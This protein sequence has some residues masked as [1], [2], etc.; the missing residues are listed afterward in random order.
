MFCAQHSHL[1]RNTRIRFERDQFGLLCSFDSINSKLFFR[2]IDSAL[3]LCARQRALSET[4]SQSVNAQTSNHWALIVAKP[5]PQYGLPIQNP[6]SADRVAQ[7]IVCRLQ[8][9]TKLPKQVIAKVNAIPSS[10]AVTRSFTYSTASAGWNG[11]LKF[12]GI[13]TV[14][15]AARRCNWPVSRFMIG[16][17]VSIVL[18][19]PSCPYLTRSS[20]PTLVSLHPYP[21]CGDLRLRPA[22]RNYETPFCNY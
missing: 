22:F 2:R 3:R 16:L 5:W 6:T 19:P 14:A 4:N 11:C 21:V 15:S 7:Q 20:V 9:P 13:P 8:Q 1:T 10:K 17:S 12:A 18:F